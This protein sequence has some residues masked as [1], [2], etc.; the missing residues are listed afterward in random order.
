MTDLSKGIIEIDGFTIKPGTTLKEM[1]EFFGKKIRLVELYTRS[2]LKF[3]DPYY[4]SDNIYAYA[5]DFNQNG[6]LFEFALIPEV[7]VELNGKYD[8]IAR[9]KLA[10]SKKWLKGMIS[11]NVEEDNNRIKYAYDWGYIV[12]RIIND[13]DYGSRGGEI[14]INFRENCSL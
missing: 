2:R 8:E 12:S 10:A 6:I 4:I 1:Q 13:R 11:E 7:P 14:I 3:L 5:F 9:H